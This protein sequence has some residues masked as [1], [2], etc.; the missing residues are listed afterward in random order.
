VGSG[1]QNAAVIVIDGRGAWEATSMWHGDK[2]RLEPVHIVPF[3][4]SLGLF[5]AE[6]THYL[7][8]SKYSDE[9]K[10]MGL[11]P[12]GAPG[13]DVSGFIDP[14][15][16]PYRVNARRLLGRDSSGIEEVLGPRRLPDA[17]ICDRHRDVAYAV[18]HACERAMLSIVALAAELTGCRTVCMA[19]GVALNSKANGRILKA[20]LVDELFIQ[21]AAGDDGAAIG[22]AFFPYLSPG[23]R[24]PIAR[25]RHV[26]LGGSFDADAENV[27]RTYK[28][29]YARLADP[30][31][32]AAELLASGRIVG[33]VQGQAEFGP[34][35]LGARSILAD[36][37]DPK[38]RDRVN[39]AVKFRESWRPF[40]PSILAEY[41]GR[42]LEDACDSPFMIITFQVRPDRREDLAAV[43]HID[44]SARPQ[45]V[46]REVNPLYWALIEE[47]RR[48]TGVPA[49]M[50]T[51]FNLRGEPIVHTPTDA[52]RTFFSSGM[53]AL[54]IGE[55]LVE[56]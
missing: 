46:E 22:A 10:V 7:G 2:G 56:K 49:I 53:D 12:Y 4:N 40:A 16:S 27:L 37:R 17:D 38:I 34:R 25:M 44:A 54:V 26:Y 43:T 35:A 32:A 42:Y 50:N 18:Q 30:S 51:S 24:L 23:G 45:T 15:D 3:P 20:G 9:W 47:F 36:P 39:D 29:R 8:F 1:F 14:E 5:Y 52:I 41:A 6:L 13:I 21:P 28:L 33:W 11:A 48:I 55:F 19:G 31:K